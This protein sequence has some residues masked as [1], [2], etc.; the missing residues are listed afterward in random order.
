[1]LESAEF[2]ERRY[3]NF[4]TLVIVP[5]FLLFLFLVVFSIFF[6]REL[7]VNA[8]GQIVPRKVLSIVQST[9]S[10]PIELN[11]LT[12]GKRVKKGDV[13]LT[14]TD[15]DGNASK[16]L[17][18]SQLKTANDRL[19]ALDSYKRSIDYGTGQFAQP[20]TFGYSDMFDNYIAQ[21][22]TLN[23]AYKQETSDK[24]AS[25]NQVDTQTAALND[26]ENQATSKISQYQTVLTAIKS[27]NKASLSGNP[28]SYIYDAYSAESDG[29][30]GDDREKVRQTSISTV[31]Q[32]INQL[33]DAVTSYQTQV[34]SIGKSADISPIT[35]EDK[36]ASLKTDQLAS[37]TKEYADQ[38]ATVDKLNAQVK[39]NDSD[40]ADNILQADQPG[41][42]HVLN[43]NTRP[44]FL[45]KGSEVAEIYPDLMVNPA[46]GVEF[47]VPADKISG[48]KTGEAIRFKVSKSISKPVILNGKITNIDTTA[49]VTKQGNFFKVTANVSLSSEEY[50]QIK[51]G[52][53]GETTVITGKKTW[54]EYIKDQ[55]FKD[56]G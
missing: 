27:D 13:L 7:T 37:A 38:K 29:L 5:V 42:L 26:A 9:S 16:A 31:Q 54:V 46:L 19:I 36:V 8:V 21:V 28:Y 4:A 44:K 22:N 10:N 40:V 41:I 34:K 52:S 53:V 50:K 23:D 11:N 51:Y 45:S 24:S 25:D 30:S 49:T 18:E 14:Y 3:R 17:L 43:G 32:A 55:I 39:V 20:D 47:M 56:E 15:D 33:N 2:Y 35:T 6:K 48:I 1:M 12:E